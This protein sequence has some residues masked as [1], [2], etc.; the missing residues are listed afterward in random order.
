LKTKPWS[1]EAPKSKKGEIVSSYVSILLNKK[2]K[3]KIF[4]PKFKSIESIWIVLAGSCKKNR[5]NQN[6]DFFAR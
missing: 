6:C 4:T 1:T 5:T 2:S 3:S